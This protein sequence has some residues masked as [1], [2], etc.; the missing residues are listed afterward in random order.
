VSNI[1][2]T[3]VIGDLL[4]IPA[5]LPVTFCTGYLVGWYGNIHRFRER[6]LVERVFWSLPL[7]LAVSTIASVLIGKFLSLTAV[8][9]FF[10]ASAL[11]S[12]ATLGIEWLRRRRSGTEWNFGIQPLGTIALTIA[13]A[14]VAGAVLSLVDFQV[15]QRLYMSLPFYDHGVRVNWSESILRTGV[16]PNNP[17]YFYGQAARLRYYYF[18]LVDCAAVSKIWHLDLRAVMTASCIWAGF[19]LA[20]IIGLYLKYFLVVGARLRRQFLVSMYLFTVGGLAVLA[21]FLKIAFLHQSARANVWYAIQIPDWW[22]ILMYYPHH[23]A[24]LVC[25]LLAFLLAWLAVHE[26]SS[27]RGRGV[28]LIAAASASAFGLSVYVAFAFFLVMLAWSAWQLA[29]E[30]EWRAPLVLALG[31]TGAFILLIPYLRELTASQGK[32]SGP[33]LFSFAIRPTIPTHYLLSLSLF[34]PFASQHPATA[35]NIARAIMLMP[36]YIIELGFFILVLAVFLLPGLRGRGRLTQSQRSL[37]FIVV[38]TFPIVSLIQSG[39]ISVNDFG[40]HSAMFL[41]VPLLLLASELVMSWRLESRKTT[42]PHLTQG[43]PRKVPR[44]LRS[45]ATLAIM[46][47]I[48]STSYRALALRFFLPLGESGAKDPKVANVAHLSHKAYISEVGYAHLNPLIPRDAIVQFNAIDPWAF[49]KNVDLVN[50][51]HQVAMAGGA[52]WCGSELGG[53]PAGCPQMVDEI[54]NLY[55]GAT[56]DQARSTCRSFAIQYLVA[57]VYDPVWK[58]KQSWVWNLTPVVADPE[59]RAVDCRN[60]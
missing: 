3:Q 39:V 4:A 28:V 18:W 56:A 24:S 34:S 41:Q 17:L 7:S 5:F 43:L 14:F 12:I 22:S 40:L 51:H 29:I 10:V 36:A 19:C 46:V 31:A 1:T 57:N 45:L 48:F 26:S 25:V 35:E 15:G 58:D 13:L 33:G 20:T 27:A 23:V 53:D 6:S 54:N 16:P 59:F 8:A 32:M 37:V 60:N 38:V 21:I 2:G 30:R 11:F 52:L 47:G 44:W 55:T 49:W 50:V 9:V 42:D